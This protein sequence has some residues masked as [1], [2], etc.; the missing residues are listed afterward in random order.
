MKFPRILKR[1]IVGIA[2]V[3]AALG[4][5]WLWQQQRAVPL[6]PGATVVEQSIN[7]LMAR[8]TTLRG[9]WS[10]EEVRAFYQQALPERGW[11]YC[12]TQ[13]TPGCTNLFQALSPENGTVDVYRRA[14]DHSGTGPTVEIW[15]QPGRMEVQVFESREQ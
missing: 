6:P 14:D 1:E 8:T 7:S 3:A 9:P 12:G 11:R 2:L 15:P 5:L 10:E 4:G 13:V